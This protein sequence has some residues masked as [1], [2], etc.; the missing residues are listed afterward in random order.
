M[1][2]TTTIATLKKERTY[3][4]IHPIA[5]DGQGVVRIS[6]RLSKNKVERTTYEIAVFDAYQGE[7][8]G[9]SF[10][11]EDGEKHDVFLNEAGHAACDCRGHQ[12]HGHCKHAS[13]VELLKQRGELH[14]P[15]TEGQEESYDLAEAALCWDVA[16]CY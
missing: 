4:W 8:I 2:E 14:L 5:Q 12:R 3:R 7:G 1:N 13:L 6:Q 10:V 15:E 16:D 9:V 11:K